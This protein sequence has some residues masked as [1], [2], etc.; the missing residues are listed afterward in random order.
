MPRHAWLPYARVFD[1]G[2]LMS[3]LCVHVV[4][5][6]GR[7]LTHIFENAAAAPT[8]QALHKALTITN[9][10]II[11]HH[12]SLPSVCLHSSGGLLDTS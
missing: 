8:A 9:A 6:L 11:G 7:A 2:L 5:C 12:P 3:G 10:I 4:K 1:A